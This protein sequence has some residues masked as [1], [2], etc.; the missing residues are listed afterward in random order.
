MCV[1]R[2]VCEAVLPLALHA[3]PKFGLEIAL[4]IIIMDEQH[5]WHEAESCCLQATQPAQAWRLRT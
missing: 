2:Q 3:R 5:S 4:L 1:K